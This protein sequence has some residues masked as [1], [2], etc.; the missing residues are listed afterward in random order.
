MR[1]L[2][3]AVALLL[4]TNSF[5]QVCTQ[6][7]VVTSPCEGVLMPPDWAKEGTLCVK[8]EL[9]RCAL[10]LQAT[11]AKAASRVASLEAEMALERAHSLKV[12]AM[13]KECSAAKITIQET[14]WYQTTWFL[15]GVGFVAGAGTV[16]G[17]SLALR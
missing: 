3:L 4:P 6:A 5:A 7:S 8:V 13:V 17:S 9:P 16:L 11:T 10:D 15:V 12:E 2:L 1:I 14:P